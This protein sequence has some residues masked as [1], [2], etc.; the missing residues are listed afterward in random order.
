MRRSI[1]TIAVLGLTALWPWA[2]LPVAAEERAKL[3]VGA[4]QAARTAAEGPAVFVH[5]ASGAGA[6]TVLV[7]ADERQRDLAIYVTDEDGQTLPDG[8]VDR[9]TDGDNGAEQLVSILTRPGTYLVQVVAPQGGEAA[10][11]IGASWLPAP[12]LAREPDP[13]GSPSSARA[14]GP[15]QSLDDALGPAEGDRWDWFVV[16]PGQA[17][18]LKVTTLA[19]EG[20]LRMELFEEARFLIP[21]AR[22]DDDLGGV[23]G[24]EAIEVQAEAGK[25]YFFRVLA[26]DLSAAKL[27]Y[28]VSCALD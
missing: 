10:F 4:M 3:P 1:T 26:V 11:Q 17:G 24:H 7:R 12:G 18:R 14:L 8:E 22:A 5:T 9:G 6:L 20:D 23:S 25:R 21:A 13:D 15:G 16:A 19:P 2:A 27:P 28:K